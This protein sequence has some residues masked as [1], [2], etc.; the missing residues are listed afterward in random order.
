MAAYIARRQAVACVIL[1]PSPWDYFTSNR[2]LQMMAPWLAMP[3]ATPAPRWFGGYP[4]RENYATLLAKSYV[5]LRLPPQ[6][7]RVFKGDLSA[8]QK[9][10][11]DANPFH[12]LGIL[13]PA[14]QQDRAFFS[15]ARRDRQ[16]AIVRRDSCCLTASPQ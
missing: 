11:P 2:K 5:T 1:F 7:I 16:F 15:A 8:S 6:N 4:A 14:Y 10:K 3:A 12:G 13:D 9:A